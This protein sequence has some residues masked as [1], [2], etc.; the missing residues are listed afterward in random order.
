VKP[1]EAWCVPL[2]DLRALGTL[3]RWPGVE[4]VV[5]ASRIWFRTDSLDEQRIEHLRRIPG[6]ERYTVFPD[7]QLVP[8]AGR[9]P[10][11]YLPSGSWRPIA[12]L[13]GVELPPIHDTL[14]ASVTGA[15]RLVRSAIEREPT[16]LRT[17][18]AI[19]TEYAATAPQVRLARWMFAADG[20]ENVLIRGTPLPPLPGTVFVDRERIIVPAGWTWS[21]HL[22]AATLREAFAI[23]KGDTL[24]WTPD[25]ACEVIR[26]S[27]LVAATR[28]AARATANA[29]SADRERVR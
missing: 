24:L 8:A 27:G 19:W 15:V 22:P 25:G 21:P 5:T 14:T 29:H 23:D 20:R 10:G 28:S 16:W 1:R 17:S 13:L 4:A 18:L 6:I 3:R 9:V 12:D 11:G 26:E 2:D 7:G